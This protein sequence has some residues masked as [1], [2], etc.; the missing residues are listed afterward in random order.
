M[1]F[2]VTH[3]RIVAD[4]TYFYNEVLQVTLWRKLIK[5]LI[6]VIYNLIV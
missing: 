5:N 1:N 6:R 2:H 4:G 3:L